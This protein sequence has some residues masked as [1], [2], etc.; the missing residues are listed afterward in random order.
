MCLIWGSTWL[1]IRW[2]L[3][4]M[5]PLTSLVGRLVVAWLALAAITPAL[6]RRAPALAPPHWLSVSTGT[7]SFALSYTVVYYTETIIPSGLAAVLWAT[8]PLFL[9]ILARFF[10]GEKLGFQKAIGLLVAFAGI[11]T[12]FGTDV[13]ALGTGALAAGLI[14]LVSPLSA[15][16]NTVIVKTHAK[17][18]SSAI[19]T[20]NALF[21]GACET[22]VLA[23]LFENTAQTEWTARAVVS[24][25]Y[26]AI[27]GTAVGFLLWFWALEHM[28][29][30]RLA[31]IS[32]I[33]PVIA[34]ALGHLLMAEPLTS[35]LAVGTS[36]VLGGVVIAAR[37]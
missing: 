27:L 5:P 29:A 9:A 33:S 17:G 12:L 30:S 7:L 13:P 16:I 18:T 14:F 19:L 28:P 10:L 8:Y 32:Y 22:A 36:L 20:R 2:G 23:L 24:V 21:V 31:L 11:V 26:L 6:Q 35:T 37:A 15:A 1:V 4:D 25:T 3:T 34:V